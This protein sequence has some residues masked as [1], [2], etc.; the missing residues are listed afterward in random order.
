MIVAYGYSLEAFYG[1]FSGNEYEWYMTKNRALG[2][3]WPSYWALILCNV[4]IP[5]S[6]WL[7]QV[8][9]NVK[10][11]WV[12][13]IIVNIGMWLERFV[14]IITSLHRDFMPSKW[15]M[16]YRHDL[17]L[18]DIHRHDRMVPAVRAP[19]YPRA[20]GRFR[21]SRC[22]NWYMKK[23]DIRT[24]IPLPRSVMQKHRVTDDQATQYLRF[25]G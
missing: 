22:A 2:P 9:Q 12:I 17:G 25:A 15:N 1:W 20:A 3:Y 18:G 10:L 23:M 5:Q 6:L 14:I 8:R 24:N 21:S 4:I 7:R 19:V 13:S 11:L 16:Y